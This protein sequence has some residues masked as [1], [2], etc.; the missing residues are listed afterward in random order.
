MEPVV[1]YLL[2]R[3]KI[4]RGQLH[5]ARRTQQFFGGQLASHLLKLGFVDEEIL[6]EALTDVSGAPYASYE[7]LRAIPAEAQER[8]PAHL[9]EVH[10]ACPFDVAQ[11]RLRVAMLNPRDAVAIRDLEKASGLQLE[12]WVTTEYR[13][14]QALERYFRIRLD[15][16]RALSLAPPAEMRRQRLRE[17]PVE[18]VASGSPSE[19]PG[20]GEVGL[21]GLPLDAEPDAAR[22][23]GLSDED[24]RDVDVPESRRRGR[25]DLEELRPGTRSGSFPHLD[26]QLAAGPDRGEIARSILEFC[27]G[28]A[29]RIALFA[30]NRS[31]IRGV[32]GRGGA[33]SDELL[34][35]VRIPR[36]R[37]AMLEQALESQDHYY[38]L[39]PADPGSRE[40]YDRLGVSAP[41]TVALYPVRVKG[42]TVA[43]LYMDNESQPLPLPDAPTMQRLTA[44]AGLALEILLLRNKLR[45]I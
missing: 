6:G 24:V 21:D 22:L 8:V 4:T 18:R 43:L 20:V 41:P 25:A 30:A 9:L 5:E 27:S 34:A 10:R 14:Y 11:D 12:T 35:S 29:G 1:K 40:V 16:L 3:S 13:L 28:F 44:K 36:E 7:R 19:A 45:D 15:G 37:S 26:H 23:W 32:A 38:G 42:R 39:V 17:E 33:F 31:D 2:D